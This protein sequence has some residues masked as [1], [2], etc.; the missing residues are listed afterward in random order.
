LIIVKY[1]LIGRACQ[2][3]WYPC[4]VSALLVVG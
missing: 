1:C 3:I 2:G 4:A